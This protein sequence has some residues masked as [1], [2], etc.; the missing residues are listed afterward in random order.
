LRHV[1]VRR[2]V[3]SA[4][5]MIAEDAG[6]KVRTMD[7]RGRPV[8]HPLG[9]LPVAILIA[10]MLV[11]SC[12]DAGTAS[13][14]PS[15]STPTPAAP[16]TPGAPSAP[17]LAPATPAPA[18]T[19]TPA[20]G[21]TDTTAFAPGALAVTVSDSI[22]VR[23]QPRVSDDSVRYQPLLPTGTQL[24]IT[25]G[26]T[27]ASGYTWYRVVP[28]DVTL[29]GGVE[30]GWVAV[31]DHDGTP[32]VA[33]ADDPTPGFELASV[34]TKRQ[35]PSVA[36]ARD[37]AAGV[38]G[39]GL[40]LYRELLRE[41]SRSGDPVNVVVSPTS[42]AL[43]LTMARAG[44]RGTTATELDGLL[45]ASG[46]DAL[47]SGMSSLQQLLASRDTAWTDWDGT[48]HALALRIA[49]AAFAQD[50]WAIREDFLQRI[51]GALGA[52]LGLLDYQ[53]DPEAAREAINA[54]VARQTAGRIPRLLNP[55][56]VSEL[57]R[58]MLVNAVYLKAQWETEFQDGATTDRTFT[59]PDGAAEQVPTMTLRGGQSVPYASG[60]GWRATELRYLG[61]NGSTPLAMTLILPDDL[62][63]FEQNL[64]TA[65]LSTIA[66]KLAGERNGLQ[67]LTDDG[68]TVDPS[69]STYAYEVHLFMPRFGIDTRAD[70]QSVLK[71]IGM[72]TAGDSATADFSGITDPSSVSI[73]RVIHQANI[74]VDEHGTEAAAATA[75][76][77]DTTG[78]CG[79]PQPKR[80]ITLRLN[81]PFLFVLRDVQTGAIL[82]LGHVVDPAVRS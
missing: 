48:A 55:S 62:A 12:G 43:A 53:G 57:T 74:D 1:T 61:A 4:L 58:L 14:P 77:M 51:D 7:S 60:S 70:L 50:G 16:A 31:A 52:G 67:R 42:V 78:G 64:T 39:F 3:S 29:D 76:G 68:T 79:Q 35:A 38:N 23:S 34:A 63:R 25:G 11:A 49:N 2:I 24:V 20:P 32:W 40:S 13:P 15:G 41:I 8:R 82:F 33:L 6:M 45:G 18:A 71:A 72:V 44:A 75:I 17:P 5:G 54:W 28:L 10:V 59:L 26:P 65:K 80:T 81:K 69:C 73:S 56:D 46:W 66:D 36:A 22:R 37:G 47:S 21:S 9:G 27:R 19:P 30:E